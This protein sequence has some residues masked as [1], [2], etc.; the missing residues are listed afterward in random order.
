M[1]GAGE[2]RNEVVDIPTYSTVLWVLKPDRLEQNAISVE[3]LQ[4]N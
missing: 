4:K 2:D 3:T 1:D